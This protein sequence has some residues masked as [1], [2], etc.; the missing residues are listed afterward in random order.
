MSDDNAGC[1]GTLIFWGVA[2]AFFVNVVLPICIVAGK[3]LFVAI[4]VGAFIVGFMLA[5][6]NYFRAVADNVDFYNWEWEKDDEPAKRS[7]FFGPGFEQMRKTFNAACEL[8]ANSR[9]QIGETASKIRGKN[10]G[11]WATFV[12][13][14]RAIV[15]V[16][17]LVVANICLGI[18]GTT[19]SLIF[20]FIHFVVTSAF[21]LLIYVLFSVIWL[22]DRT[23]L[24]KNKI[25]SDCPTCHRRFL[26]PA[27]KCPEC[28]LIH[29]KLVPGPYGIWTHKCSCGHKLP[30]TFMNGRAKL[31]SFCPK[32]IDSHIV[33]SDVRPLVFQLVGGTSVGKTVFLS[34]YFH[35]LFERLKTNLNI[36][37]D[38][39][40]KEK[41]NFEEL[42]RRYSGGADESTH[43]T[44]SKMYPIL[45]KG[46]S[47]VRR[48]FSIYDI[49]G[50]MFD[51]AKAEEEI[52]Q[53][54]FGYCDGFLFLIDPLSSEKLRNNIIDSG[55]NIS[56][57]SIMPTE[58]IVTNFVNYLISRGFV[59]ADERCK[60]PMA[61]LISKGDIREVKREI[62][63]V[64]IAAIMKRNPELYACYEEAR[65]G[66]CR[67]FLI[68][69]GLQPVVDNLEAGFSN[70]HYF[71]ISAMGHTPDG[72]EYEPWGIMEAVEWML[73]L[74][75]EKFADM[76][77]QSNEVGE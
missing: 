27:F 45:V 15:A 44:N 47:G 13:A 72:T 41:L 8:N 68:N 37:I 3:F 69:I 46:T 60:I 39:P 17:Y 76:V 32:C 67:K 16:L 42:E 38:I 22:I 56:C 14:I 43:E 49:A 30:A 74:V 12:Y 62:G 1:F 58:S 18:V 61:V 6:F 29:R 28:G 11:G 65:D 5:V 48:Q 64:R 77:V 23:Y 66:E 24:Y 9:K 35:E 52:T 63:P 10:G 25:H 40:E 53:Q 7:Y 70:L 57:H 33:A 54:H 73:P 55:R 20:G 71:P 34:A 26:I 19:L 50:E 59:R 2:I 31:E 51:G 21:M 4:S 36:D 75:D